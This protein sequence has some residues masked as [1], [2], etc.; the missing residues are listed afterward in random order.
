MANQQLIIS[1]VGGQGILFATRILAETA[2]RKGLPVMTSE[3]HGMA[4]RGGVVISHLKVGDYSSPL[5]RPGRADGLLALK[6]ENVALHRHFLRSGGWVVANALQAA[7]GL[8]G[9]PVHLLDADR[10][11]LEL[12]NPQAVN[13]ILLGFALACLAE[14]G[15]FCSPHEVIETVERRLAEKGALR[16]AALKALRL[17]MEQVSPLGP[18]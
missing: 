14:A 8:D 16:A 10:L 6:G 5:V 17:G 11:A 1:G 13:L 9:H 4:Q 3:T 7:A 15:L 18:Q 2:M 12:G